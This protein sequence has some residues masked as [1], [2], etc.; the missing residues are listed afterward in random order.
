MI[1][2]TRRHFFAISLVV[3]IGLFPIRSGD[4]RA[5]TQAKGH[6][7]LW[8]VRLYPAD[9]R[10]IEVVVDSR[11]IRDV[12]WDIYYEVYFYAEANNLIAKLSLRFTKPS[13]ELRPD[14]YV[15]YVPNPYSAAG[16]V[17]GG[18]IRYTTN[19]IGSSY[20]CPG[21]CPPASSGRISFEDSA[22]GL[23]NDG[24]LDDSYP[25]VVALEFGGLRPAHGYEWV[26]KDDGDDFRVR[27]RP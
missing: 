24:E 8:S 1:R 2:S 15:T 3:A 27:R 22:V 6:A 17:Q 26:N 7:M 23:T 9:H 10:Y 20:Y 4:V 16:R 14:R 12:A 25:N 13:E 5:Q 19:A 18:K 11:R 21:N